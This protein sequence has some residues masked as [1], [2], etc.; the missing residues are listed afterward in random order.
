MFW[1]QIL[2]WHSR[3]T[4]SNESCKSNFLKIGGRPNSS[5]FFTGYQG[6]NLIYYDPHFIRPALPLRDVNSYNKQDLFSYHCDKVR[7]LRISNLDPSMVLGFLVR[8]QNEFHSFCKDIQ[9][10]KMRLEND[11]LKLLANHWPYSP[12][13]YSKRFN[14]NT[15]SWFIYSFRWIIDDILSRQYSRSNRSDLY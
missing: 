15:K 8:D 13:Q 5:L 11:I 14:W 10:V 4:T 1:Y 2:R 9:E 7:F 3:Y 12:F 6:D